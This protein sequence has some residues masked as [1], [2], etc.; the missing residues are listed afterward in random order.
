[1]S[2]IKKYLPWVGLGL[3]AILAL[4]LLIDLFAPGLNLFLKPFMKWFTL[5][6]CL[7]AAGTGAVMIARVRESI[8]R[9]RQRPRPRRRY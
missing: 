7:A 4:M 2:I 3:C 5:V 1:M 6:A 9:S 8:R